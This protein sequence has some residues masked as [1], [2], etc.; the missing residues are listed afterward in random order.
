M[1]IILT[2]TVLKAQTL[3]TDPFDTYAVASSDTPA[4]S[5]W[6]DENSELSQDL[7]LGNCTDWGFSRVGLI[8]PEGDSNTAGNTAL[9]NI[10]KKVNAAYSANN[11]G[12][13]FKPQRFKTNDELNEYSKGSDYYGKAL[14]FTIGWNTFDP[15]QKKF[16]IDMRWNPT[17]GP[18]T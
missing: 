12:K 11:D 4:T 15:T 7:S 16:D 6:I 14:C 2:F 3:K 17:Q 9:D 18:I 10:F 13:E 5:Y 8:Q 1:L